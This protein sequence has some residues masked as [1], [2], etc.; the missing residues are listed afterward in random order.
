VI[1]WGDMVVAEFDNLYVRGTADG[2][3]VEGV[4]VLDVDETNDPDLEGCTKFLVPAHLCRPLTTTED[5]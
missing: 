3:E 2:N 5:F 1:K 4:V